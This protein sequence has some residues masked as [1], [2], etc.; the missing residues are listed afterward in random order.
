VAGGST[1]SCSWLLFYWACWRIPPELYESAR[2]DG[3]RGLDGV[4]A[5]RLAAGPADD[6]S[7]G[8]AG[9]CPVLGDSRRRCCISFG[10]S[11]YTLPIGLQL[12][13][14]MDSTNLPLL[15]AGSVMMTA[16]RGSAVPGDTAAVLAWPNLGKEV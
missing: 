1:A 7:G 3:G 4:A 5:D 16:P 11:L 6:G 12:L 2:L 9:F 15:M 13:K 10:P 14:Q 8:G